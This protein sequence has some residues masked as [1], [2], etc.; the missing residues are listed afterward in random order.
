MSAAGA[1]ARR[2]LCGA[3]I[4][5]LALVPGVFAHAQA[6]YK[7]KGADGRITYS[8]M[9]CA[10]DGE[11]LAITTQ[12]RVTGASPAPAAAT[13]QEP[14]APDPPRGADAGGAPAPQ[15]PLPKQCDNVGVLQLVIAR[16]DSPRTPDDIRPFLADERFRLVRC[17]YTRF[18]PEERRERD[19]AMQDLDAA[20]PARRRAAALRVEALYDR[21][22]TSADRA[23][24]ERKRP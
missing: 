6:I 21:H 14:R 15:A 11:R 18:T 22:L 24:R 9:A 2:R 7:C 17:E 5:V 16:L 20:D 12:S 4:V 8:S 19:G 1:T 13:P 10:G 3:G 23:A